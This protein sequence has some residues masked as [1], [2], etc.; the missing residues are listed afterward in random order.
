MCAQIEF[1]NK[2]EAKISFLVSAVISAEAFYSAAS[3]QNALRLSDVNWGIKA[4][5]AEG[6]ELVCSAAHSEF[7]QSVQCQAQ[8]AF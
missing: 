8:I 7:S 3:F 6:Y 1:Y 4:L 5:S 2:E